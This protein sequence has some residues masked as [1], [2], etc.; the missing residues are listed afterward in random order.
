MISEKAENLILEFEGMDQPGIWPG[1]DSGVTLG[2]GYD[3]GYAEGYKFEEDWGSYLDS[4]V[5]ARLKTA[6]GLKG[7][8]AKAKAKDFKDIKILKS[9][10]DEVFVNS[11]IPKYEEITR[12]AFPGFDD[13]LED[14]Q[15]ALVSLVYNRGAS[16]EDTDRRKEMR[17]IRD[18]I[19]NLYGEGKTPTSEDLNAGLESISDC[20]LSMKRL[21][22]GKNLD[23][24]LRRRDAEAELVRSCII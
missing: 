22:E 18:I 17:E 14:A 2:H 10:A 8:T 5:I 15:G 11:S 20:I 23:G 12:E 3:L 7:S 13:L 21:W 16:M 9:D 4:A 6:I 19:S 1:G 24:L